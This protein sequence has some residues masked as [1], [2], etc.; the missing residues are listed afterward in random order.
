[1]RKVWKKV[2]R[3]ERW[4]GGRG[5]VGTVNKEERRGR[6]ERKVRKKVDGMIQGNE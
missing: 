4:G 2:E 1:M 5:K 6:N 3:K